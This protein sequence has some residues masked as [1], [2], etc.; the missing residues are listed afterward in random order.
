[1]SSFHFTVRINSKSFTELY[2]LYKKPTE[3]FGNVGC[4]IL[5]KP[6]PLCRLADGHRSKADLSW[7]LK[8]SNTTDDADITQS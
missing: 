1:M 2:A 7:K 6:T 3:I 4:P 5:G 8:I